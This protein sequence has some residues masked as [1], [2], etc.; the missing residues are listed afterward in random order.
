MKIITGY[1]SKK[2]SQFFKIFFFGLGSDFGQ[3]FFW[4]RWVL[5]LKIPSVGVFF[6]NFWVFGV[7]L[8]VLIVGYTQNR[9]VE[10]RNRGCLALYG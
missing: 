5:N 6:P 3:G 9:A 4:G 8:L 2:F 1:H 10:R 7:F